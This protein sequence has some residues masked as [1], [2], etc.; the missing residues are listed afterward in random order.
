MGKYVQ[1]INVNSNCAFL[2]PETSRARPM[3]Y[4]ITDRTNQRSWSDV[5]QIRVI[6]IGVFC[7][8]SQ[9]FFSRNATRAGSEEGPLFSQAIKFQTF[10]KEW[11]SDFPPVRIYFMFRL[12]SNNILRVTSNFAYV[13]LT[14]TARFK[15]NL[16]KKDLKHKS[17]V[18]S[19][20]S[21]IR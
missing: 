18:C 13:G 21:F 15:S 17:A 9:T 4:I 16:P 2:R 10:C 1:Y 6:S 19:N 11:N 12:S 20:G 3:L 7:A 14:I 8:E 5:G